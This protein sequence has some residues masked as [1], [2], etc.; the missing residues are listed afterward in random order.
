MR[1]RSVEVVV[2][3]S[4]EYHN[5][6]AFD[7]ALRAIKARGLAHFDHSEFI[8]S[9]TGHVFFRVRATKLSMKRKKS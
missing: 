2:K 1:K 3:L 6:A 8:V 7:A 9:G 4:V 5:D